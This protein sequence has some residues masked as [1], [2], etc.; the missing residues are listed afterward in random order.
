MLFIN[1]SKFIL[2]MAMDNKNLS[3][4]GVI[5]G[6]IAWFVFIIG[7]AAQTHNTCPSVFLTSIVAVSFIAPAWF[8]AHIVSDIFPNKKD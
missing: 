6:V 8:A 2:G 1:A 7:L 4:I 3:K 5:A